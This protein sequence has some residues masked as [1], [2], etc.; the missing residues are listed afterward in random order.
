M[1]IYDVLMNTP[2]G[3]RKGE[4]KAKIENGKTH[5]FSFDVRTHGAN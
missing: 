5:R 1:K 4:L 2:L 3:K